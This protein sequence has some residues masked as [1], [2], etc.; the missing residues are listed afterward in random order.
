L[1]RKALTQ[2]LRQIPT[3]RDHRLLVGTS[4]GDDAGV[5][6]IGRD[7]ALVQ[8][9][10]FFTPVVDDAGTYGQIAAANGLSDVYAMGGRPLTA[11]N[12]VGFPPDRVPL[13]VVNRILRGGASTLIEAKCV[14]LGGH[15]IRNPEP[16]YGLAVTGLVSPRLMMTNAGARPGDAL[17]LTKPIGSGIV[18]TAIKREL[19]APS[20]RRK[21]IAVM[22]QL[23]TAGP[24]IAER[25]L[26][27]AAVDI[28]GFGLLGHLASM[29]SASHVG[30]VIVASAV[31]PIAP[32]V[33][34]LIASGCVP[35]GSRDNQAEA[36]RFT[37]WD[38][39]SEG[40]RTLLSD[41]QTSGGLLLSVAP[42]H[43]DAVLARLA[44]LRS[45]CAAVIGHIVRG[46]PRIRVAA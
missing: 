1:S 32:S 27:H 33:F 16:L 22:K 20:L 46:N 18:T 3:V 36:S 39:V 41:A 26:A 8:T 19:A 35:G 23:N 25:R 37:D 5:Y 11:L 4:T 38:G 28:T 12:V 10:D 44:A 42:K 14:L 31:P 24:D 29:C 2:V 6:L 7:R 13:N 43:I 30:A 45:P 15:T 34:E 40:Y 21:A 17:I 9:V